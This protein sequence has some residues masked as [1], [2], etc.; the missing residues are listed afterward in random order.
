[1]NRCALCSTVHKSKCLGI[2]EA[3]RVVNCMYLQ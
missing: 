1:M 2:V 3:V